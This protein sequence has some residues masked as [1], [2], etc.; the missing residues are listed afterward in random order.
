MINKSITLCLGL[1]IDCSNITVTWLS[2]P[3]LIKR[4][5]EKNCIEV[6]IDPEAPEG[7]RC[8][9]GLIYCLN[10][11]GELA[12][13]SC[14][15]THFYKCFCTDKADC[16]SCQDCGSDGL[17]YDTCTPEELAQ[18][19]I[20]TTAGCVCPPN[21][22]FK[23]PTTGHCVSCL[24][25]SVHPTNPCLACVDGSWVLKDCGE[26][27]ICDVTITDGDN[28][29][30]DCSKN[31]DGRTRWNNITKQCDCEEGFYWD[32]T[33]CRQNP[34]DCGKGKRWNPAISECEDIPCPTGFKYSTELD[35]N[36]KEKGCIP[37]C[38]DKPCKNGL[39]C[40]GKNCGCDEPT[41]KCVD[42]SKNPNA[43]G[44]APC[45]EVGLPCDGTTVLPA[46]QTCFEGKTVCCSNFPCT[47]CGS[48]K[49]CNCLGG[50]CGDDGIDDGCSD[51]VTLK[52]TGCALEAKLVKN[53][54]CQCEI[55]SSAAVVTKVGLIGNRKFASF[56]I[57]IRK[58]VA[59]NEVQYELLPLFT[60]DNIHN[61][62][63]TE[64]TVV[65]KI[66][67]VYRDLTT[68]STFNLEGQTNTISFV[69]KSVVTFSDIPVQT[70]LNNVNLLFIGYKVEV[71]VSGLKFPNNCLYK[72]TLLYKSLGLENIDNTA[73]K[74]YLTIGKLSSTST[75]NPLATWKINGEVKRKFYIQ[76]DAPN[77]FIDKLYGP[78][79]FKNSTER[80]EQELTTPRAELIPLAKYEIYFDCTCAAP[81]TIDRLVICDLKFDYKQHFDVNTSQGST[82][83]NNRLYITEAF[84]V[85][86]INQDLKYFGWGVNH[87]SQT[88]YI[89]SVN[90][91]DVETFVFK[92][93]S[94]TQG[95]LVV[96]GT[97]NSYLGYTKIFNEQIQTVS[98]RM[99]HDAGCVKE[100]TIDLNICDPVIQLL[101][102][103]DGG[104]SATVVPTCSAIKSV[105]WTKENNRTAPNVV[106]SVQP[107][108]SIILGGLPSNENIDLT[109]TFAN[110]CKRSYVISKNCCLE[111][112]LVIE[113][114]S[115]V[116]AELNTEVVL[117]STAKNQ[118]I[119]DIF[120]NGSSVTFEETFTGSKTYKL[121][122]GGRTANAPVTIKVITE[123]D[124]EYEKTITLQSNPGSSISFVPEQICA[125]G[126]ASLVIQTQV[127][128]AP[129]VILNPRG[130]NITGTTDSSGNATITNINI[131]GIYTLISFNNQSVSDISIEL[132][133]IEQPEITAF[134]FVNPGPYC[135]GNNVSFN[136]QGT[137]FA[138]VI[139]NA[140]GVQKEVILN[141]NGY[142]TGFYTFTS[143]G[144]Y[145]IV[146]QS[147]QL[148][149]CVNPQNHTLQA[150]V[151]VSPVITNVT[152]D[153]VAP[154]TSTSDVLLQVTCNVSGLTVTALVNNVV[155]NLTPSTPSN[156]YTV[157]VPVGSSKGAII[158]A[159]NGTCDT[160]QNY[161]L[162][163]CN[164]QAVGMPFI[165]AIP[166]HCGTDV[167]VAFTP[168]SGLELKWFDMLNGNV[169]LSP[170]AWSKS[171]PV[172]IYEVQ[173]IDVAT[174]C[175][176][177][178]V[179]FEILDGSIGMS[180]TSNKTSACQNEQ[181][182]FNASVTANNPNELLYQWYVNGV[183]KPSTGSSY[184][185]T[186][187]IVGSYDV[188]C[189]VQRNGTSCT[190]TDLINV[191]VITCCTQY[192]VDVEKCPA[193]VASVPTAP[194]GMTFDYKWYKWYNGSNVL[195]QTN[196]NVLSST[197]TNP[198]SLPQGSLV[199]V[200]V[201]N[202]AIPT[203][204]IGEVSFIYNSPILSATSLA[205]PLTSQLANPTYATIIIS[206][207]TA[208][209]CP[210]SV[211]NIMFNFTGGQLFA[212]LN[213]GYVLKNSASCTN[214]STLNV[215]DFINDVNT[216]LTSL[217]T[218]A[219]ISWDNIN[220]QFTYSTVDTVNEYEILTIKY[221][222]TLGCT[223]A[224]DFS[225]TITLTLDFP[226]Q[227]P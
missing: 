56:Q 103:D 21:K 212:G 202:N 37:D 151:N 73:T 88:K 195:I 14:E 178:R 196:S 199:T 66:T 48:L 144:T 210:T 175:E 50:S 193:P 181:I 194:T 62:L 209:K 101:C 10:E 41:E 171:L 96:E 20:C 23:H 69:N 131:S 155:Y 59:S 42:C 78:Y 90:G 15:P 153:C 85:C 6:A 158:T 133:Q 160:T 95:Q 179:Q 98:L 142:G 168:Q 109:V 165:N 38:I 71:T 57:D 47:I 84:D 213:N 147:I 135:T 148:V 9:E 113:Q 201:Y 75:K 108:G 87:P 154:I 134:S 125:D 218:N 223:L 186:G 54:I 226:C 166:Y 91:V 187:D 93:T 121:T 192:P 112:N 104:I 120:V 227:C 27:N 60:N 117:V 72:D 152:S 197:F 206:S 13:N 52:A 94:D 207:V 150:V 130:S 31:T 132:T 81:K 34:K 61:E 105:G 64:G 222:V 32:G 211:T 220:N 145:N 224:G 80:G 128:N 82:V 44:C 140:N 83:C 55:I 36:G 74:S 183:L 156:I 137:P 129:Y 11:A 8:L 182:E 138:K 191:S 5:E 111:D 106:S 122:I 161:T 99:N 4:C 116:F 65:L 141:S 107:N 3:G 119:T 169:E 124:C 68:D 172:G 123:A 174:G 215:T 177:Q 89:L 35:E 157:N 114:Q 63:P 76:P 28:C 143:A 214:I 46:G 149:G 136:I 33:R 170:N 17:C 25:G 198:T 127:A 22:P 40:G 110:D 219:T 51:L 45:G 16:N 92:N 77:T 163:N 205:E 100:N 184:F 203:C 162:A 12:C 79:R 146:A 49:G 190:A 29:I 115:I 24:E 180:L 19:K 167:L 58:G 188:S 1:D 159:S 18:G 216:W 173:H 164:C 53:S 86:P 39:D 7:Q 139:L 67:E 189:I 185:F 118:I 217:G 43:L 204:L 208:K 26:G 102:D 126:V 70:N 221:H 176:S 225:N 30:T 97:N 200:K 2:H